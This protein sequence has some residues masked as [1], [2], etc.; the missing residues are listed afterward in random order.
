MKEYKNYIVAIIIAGILTLIW[1]CNGANKQEEFNENIS[2]AYENAFNKHQSYLK[3]QDSLT[4]SIE[5]WEKEH[6]VF[7]DDYQPADT[8]EEE[9]Q[10]LQEDFKQLVSQHEEF[11]NEHE[12]FLARI[13][14]L[15]REVQE[16][17]EKVEGEDEKVYVKIEEYLQEHKE[18]MEEYRQIKKK[19]DDYLYGHRVDLH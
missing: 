17:A 14:S 3:A 7:I 5:I 1:R 13:D 4:A 18:M 9:H 15:K 10:M 19:H 16:Q 6:E 12:E 8:L 2:Q 11:V